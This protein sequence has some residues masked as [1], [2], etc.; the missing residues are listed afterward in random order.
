M[1][2]LFDV[3]HAIC[4]TVELVSGTFLRILLLKSL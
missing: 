3:A 4:R 1:H 2:A